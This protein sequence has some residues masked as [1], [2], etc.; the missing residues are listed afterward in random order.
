V[1]SKGLDSTVLNNIGVDP[2]VT[3][4]RILR[5]GVLHEILL[6]PI[7]YRILK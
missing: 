5:L 2:E 3:T 1:A 6:Y 4:P 7:M